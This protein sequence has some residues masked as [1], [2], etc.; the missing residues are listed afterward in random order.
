VQSLTRIG[1]AGG[2]IEVLPHCTRCDA[3][4]FS[5]RR[6]AGRT[7]RHLSVIACDFGP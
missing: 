7:G 1:V 4:F 2:H 6:E 5:H 3:R